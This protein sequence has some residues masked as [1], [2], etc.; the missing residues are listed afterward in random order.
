M[1]LMEMYVKFAF[2]SSLF[3]WNFNSYPW[4]FSQDLFAV[5]FPL[6]SILDAPI[7]C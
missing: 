7:R 6:C 1:K 4:A 2:F 5:P 3:I